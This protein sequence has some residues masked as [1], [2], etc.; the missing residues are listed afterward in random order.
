MNKIQTIFI[1]MTRET[2]LFSFNRK[3]KS[4]L[5]TEGKRKRQQIP[6]LQIN[7]RNIEWVDTYKYLGIIINNRLS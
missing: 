6:H 1:L 3:T 7:G 5:F 4:I 2:Q